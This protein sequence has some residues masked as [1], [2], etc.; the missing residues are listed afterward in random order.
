MKLMIQIKVTPEDARK[1][2]NNMVSQG[3]EDV[4]EPV[5][6]WREDHSFRLDGVTSA[7]YSIVFFEEDDIA[8]IGVR[9]Q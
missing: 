9:P 1:F 7:D 4:L 6:P 2:I 5:T 8:F 3:Y